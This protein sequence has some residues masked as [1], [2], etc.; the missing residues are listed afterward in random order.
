MK[1]W[2]KVTGKDITDQ[3]VAFE[4][5]SRRLPADYQKAWDDIT[6]NIWPHTSLTGRNLL[7]ILDNAL[8]LLEETASEGLSARE[9]LGDDIPGFAA[10]LV[11]DDGAKTYRDKWRDQLNKTV[12]QKLGMEEQK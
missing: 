6:T 2:D 4:A 1:F 11:S 5:R 9:V 12:A 7:P 8:D 3:L 10:A